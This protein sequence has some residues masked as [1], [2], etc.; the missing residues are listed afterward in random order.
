MVSATVMAQAAPTRPR[1]VVG[2]MVDGLNDDYL[3]L[4]RHKFGTDGFNRLLTQ[5]LVVR[6][7]E[8]GTA[9]DDAAAT[10]AIYTGTA[11]AINGIGGARSYDPEKRRAVAT[12]NDASKI[13]NYT[14]ETYSP[15]AIRVSTL[16]DEVRID[17]DG[18]GQVH[19]IAPEAAQAIIM[20][21]H[22]A[23]SSFWLNDLTGQWAT[24]TYY[25]D[26]PT[27]IQDINYRTPLAT[28]LDTMS[29]S[30]A[31]SLDAYP[32]L[33]QHKRYY[34]FK[35]VFPHSDGDRYKRFKTSP[36][37]NDEITSIASRY[38]TSMTLGT[39]DAIDMLNIAYTLQPYS[40]AKD[41][42]TRLETM[43]AYLKL[44][45]DLGRLLKVIDKSVGMD[46]AVIFMAGTPEKPS[47]VRDD[48]KWAL[49]AGEF[50]TRRAI[51]LLNVY[52][53]A[54]YGN[55]DWVQG[56]H[57]GHLYLNR[58]LI[59]ER[60]HDIRKMRADAADFLS[61]M[62]G[63]S[64]VHTI[65]DITSGRAGINPEA[66][67]RNT[68]AAT[69]G[70]LLITV[71]PGWVTVDD[72]LTPAQQTVN[73]AASTTAPFILLSPDVE[74]RTIDTPVDARA[75]APTVARVLR[76]R[77]PNAAEMSPVR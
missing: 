74:A 43:D 2:I 23:N 3:Q 44:D 5:G 42:D 9:L 30:P 32:C 64:R 27:T 41:P 76:I 29:W 59:K 58:K 51:S 36:K 14:N 12:L 26:V 4:L 69:A 35:Y 60:D 61:R 56:Y 48:P 15:A 22:A 16:S 54:I 63:V 67:R 50:S 65:D 13:G 70:D 53:M 55:G 20:A 33:P 73:R 57:N 8:F 45:A 6:D 49:P 11:P 46:N 37:I 47:P 75:I 38:I 25:K 1:L 71:N 77:S 7:V 28:R 52:L 66:T 34:A 24:T 68:V 10:A 31:L 21:G 18:V 17:G 39:R 62:S 19:A 40:G 72:T